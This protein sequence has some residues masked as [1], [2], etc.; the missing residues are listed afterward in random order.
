MRFVVDASAGL[1]PRLVNVLRERL[2][3]G[4]ARYDLLVG[5]VGVSFAAHGL[6]LHP[7]RWVVRVAC[8]GRADVVVEPPDPVGE[9]AAAAHL[10]DRVVRAVARAVEPAGAR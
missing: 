10:A 8:R 4:L 3:A 9:D 1:D 7:G 5:R 6:G 2:V